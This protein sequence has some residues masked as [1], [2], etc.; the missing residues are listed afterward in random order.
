MFQAVKMA[1]A[2][3]AVAAKIQVRDLHVQYVGFSNPPSQSQQQP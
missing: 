2:A 1:K 3:T